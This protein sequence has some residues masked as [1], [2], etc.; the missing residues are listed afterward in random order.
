MK[1]IHNLYSPGILIL[2]EIGNL[3]ANETLAKTHLFKGV[4]TEL[5]HYIGII[6]VKFHQIP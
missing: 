4:M 5:Q 3:V 1:I 2:L 6:H